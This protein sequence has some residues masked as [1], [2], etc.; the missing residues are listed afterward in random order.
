MIKEDALKLKRSYDAQLKEK[1]NEVLLMDFMLSEYEKEDD[2]EIRP[3]LSD[4]GDRRNATSI[5]KSW[6]PRLFL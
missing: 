4:V 5:L 1:I 6:T 3:I 2:F